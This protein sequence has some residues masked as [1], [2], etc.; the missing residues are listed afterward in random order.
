MARKPSAWVP[1]LLEDVELSGDSVRAS[2][3]PVRVRQI[4]RNLISN[5]IRYGGDKIEISIGRKGSSTFT[6]VSDDG[7]AIE[8]GDVEAIF[9]PYQVATGSSP[10]FGSV[11]LG[12]PVSRQLAR[13]MEG[14]LLYRHSDGRSKFV[15][16]LPVHKD[17]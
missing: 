17:N 6:V 15:L 13:L 1:E 5:A 9:E 12:L 3:D 8:P 14:E 7:P 2:A 4:V 10:P 11:G 16:T